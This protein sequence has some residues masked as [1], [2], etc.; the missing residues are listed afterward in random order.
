MS[1]P[2]GDREPR[3]SDAPPWVVLLQKSIVIKEV[4]LEHSRRFK[5]QQQG[6]RSISEW[7][8]A[9]VNGR[10]FHNSVA[11]SHKIDRLAILVMFMGKVLGKVLFLVLF[12]K[13]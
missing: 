4:V 7:H 1:N 6:S 2:L 13:L 5:L 10:K 8:Q 3:Q 12:E 11:D 9:V